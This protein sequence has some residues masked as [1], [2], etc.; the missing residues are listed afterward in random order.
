MP[1]ELKKPSA[2]TDTAIVVSMPRK[3]PVTKAEVIDI[4]SFLAKKL[5]IKIVSLDVT[6][7]SR[8]KLLAINKKFLKHDYET[9]IITFAYSKSKKKIEG[10]L[11]LSYEDAEENAKKFAVTFRSEL[12][13]LIVHGILHLVGYDDLAPADKRI[14][15]KKQEQL[16]KSYLKVIQTKAEV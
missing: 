11:L 8:K 9:D 7:I 14:M 3:T 12:F 4:L 5:E 10:E 16:L 13:R 1:K 2:N 6:V 15:M